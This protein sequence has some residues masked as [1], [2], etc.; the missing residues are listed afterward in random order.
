MY[1]LCHGLHTLGQG[2]V[3]RSAAASLKLVQRATER[4][5]ALAYEGRKEFHPIAEPENEDLVL[6]F[7]RGQKMFDRV[8]HAIELVDHAPARVEDDR[9]ADGSDVTRTK[10]RNLLART[11]LEDS[12]RLLLKS[13]DALARSIRDGGRQD[14]QVGFTAEDLC[15]GL[16]RFL[17][18]ADA[19]QSH[20]ERDATPN[21]GA[22]IDTILRRV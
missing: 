16:S 2:V 22:H 21:P 13:A 9:D 17:R 11:I 3:Q 10:E 7:D 18:Q 1:A 19:R 14:D 5:L 8:L 12:K 15:L 6:G 4:S 20:R